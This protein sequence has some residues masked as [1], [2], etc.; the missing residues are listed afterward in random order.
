MNRPTI[1]SIEGNIGSGKTTVIDNLEKRYKDNADI[2]FL[3]EPVDVWNTIKTEK[4]TTILENF[5]EDSDKY[6]FPFQVMAFATR[7]ASIKRAIKNNPNCKYIV[8]ERSLE[9]DNNIFA[10]MLKDDGKIED[11]QYKI[12]EH[13]YENCK[14]DVQTDGVV[15]IDSCPSVCME[16]INKRDRTGESGIEI[17]YIQRCRDYHDVWLVDNK[18]DIPVIRINTNEDVTYDEN[19][20]DDKGN[21]WLKSIFKFITTLNNNNTENGTIFLNDDKTKTAA[22]GGSAASRILRDDLHKYVA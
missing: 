18:H 17:D 5:Y 7:S 21:V 14:D 20:L 19:D 4:G 1:I 8:C 13:F 10:K 16:R 15:Y 9:A 11:I 22:G 2:V 12:Y 3:R 6:A